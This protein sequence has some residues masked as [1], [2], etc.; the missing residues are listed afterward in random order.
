MKI[1]F[2]PNWCKYLSLALFISSFA[3]G[4]NDFVRGFEAG[5]NASKNM[6]DAV[7]LSEFSR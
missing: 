7:T 6:D 4:I 5:Y 1:A 2:L 3:L